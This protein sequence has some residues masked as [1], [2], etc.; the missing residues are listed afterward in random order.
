MAD[1]RFLGISSCR[2]QDFTVRIIRLRQKCKEID[3]HSFM[4]ITNTSEII[5][6]GFRSD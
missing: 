3:P 5:G 1:S 4:F 6:K 2:P